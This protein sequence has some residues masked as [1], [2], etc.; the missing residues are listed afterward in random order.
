MI[1]KEENS[2]LESSAKGKRLENRPELTI[3][4]FELEAVSRFQLVCDDNEYVR[5]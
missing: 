3:H 1:A 4:H 5:R 2:S